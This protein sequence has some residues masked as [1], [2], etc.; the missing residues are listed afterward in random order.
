MRLRGWV[1][2]A[3]IGGMAYPFLVYVGLS[4][5]PPFFLL[6]LGIALIALRG[7]GLRRLAIGRGWLTAPALAVCGLLVLAQLSPPLAVKAYPIAISLTVAAVFGLSLLYPPTAIERFARLGEPDLSPGGVTYTRKVTWVWLIFLLAN[8]GISA[9]TA[10]WGSLEQW[11]LWNGFLSYLAMGLLFVGELLVRRRC[12][13]HRE[14]T[15]P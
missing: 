1:A 4:A 15:A 2:L 5:I 12:R 13:Q 3:A 8:A 7:V 6:L 9:A 14:R 11:T 10:L